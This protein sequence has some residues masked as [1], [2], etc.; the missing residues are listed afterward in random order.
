MCRDSTPYRTTARPCTSHASSLRRSESWFSPYL[1]SKTRSRKSCK[2][3][4]C[5]KHIVRIVQV[6]KSEIIV[7]AD[8]FTFPSVVQKLTG[9]NTTPMQCSRMSD[10]QDVLVSTTHHVQSESHSREQK[11]DGSASSSCASEARITFGRN[12]IDLQ[13]TSCSSGGAP[14]ISEGYDYS[15]ISQSSKNRSL[16]AG[17]NQRGVNEQVYE[18][19]FYDRDSSC[20]TNEMDIWDALTSNDP[21]PDVT[22]IP[23]L[24]SQLL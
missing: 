1:M 9:N 23:P 19:I 12:N 5:D 20:P 4:G 2:S 22:M 15:Q 13:S 14:N 10:C 17:D 8:I 18:S 7:E 21:L 6:Q 3:Y 16:S 24:F 11:L